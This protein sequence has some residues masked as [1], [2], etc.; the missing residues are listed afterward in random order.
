MSV[1]LLRG[2]GTQ[3]AQAVN[4]ILTRAISLGE[5]AADIAAD[6]GQA[7]Q[8][9]LQRTLTVARDGIYK[10]FRSGLSDQ[11]L[12]SHEAIGWIWTA[13]LSSK[14]CAACIAMNG[15]KHD[16]S[17]TLDSHVNCR[18]HMTPIYPGQE[19]DIQSGADWF[20]EQNA[21]TQQEILGSQ[22]AFELYASGDAS[23]DDFVG[24]D[25]DP[26]YGKSIY[27]RSAK[28]VKQLVKA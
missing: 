24:T 15:T 18:C 21:D 3:A 27:Q 8:S 7:L 13:E 20:D 5:S 16:I 9:T 2:M 22:V 1:N 14:T 25:H 23:L 26:K 17:E 12:T 19:P 4:G 10:V 28:Q 11:L 6:I